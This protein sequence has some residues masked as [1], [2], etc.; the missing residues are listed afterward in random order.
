MH[1]RR[2]RMPATQPRVRVVG[3][4]CAFTKFSMGTHLGQRE[5]LS[6]TPYALRLPRS[7]LTLSAGFVAITVAA[8]RSVA[9][10]LAS[11]N[12]CI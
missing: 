3:D 1:I 7:G 12:A 2:R 6:T 4:G 5:Y 10:R 8:T 9:S 11:R